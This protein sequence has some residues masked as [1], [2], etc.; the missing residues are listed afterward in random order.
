MK[1][2]YS[3]VDNVVRSGHVSL[4]AQG[5]EMAEGA[6]RLVDYISKDGEVDTT[7]LSTVGSKVRFQDS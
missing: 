6:K 7:A 5:D 4:P 1:K 3:L 2:V